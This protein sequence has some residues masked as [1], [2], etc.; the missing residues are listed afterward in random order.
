[1]K[2]AFLI[3][4]WTHFL[5]REIN[6]VNFADNSTC[7]RIFL[8]K[9]SII[10]HRYFRITH[11]LCMFTTI[12]YNTFIILISFDQSLKNMIACH[13]EKRKFFNPI[14]Q[15][16]VLRSMSLNFKIGDVTWKMFFSSATSCIWMKNDHLTAA[17]SSLIKMS[18]LKV[19]KKSL[20]LI[21]RRS[22]ICF[23]LKKNILITAWF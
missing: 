7:L 10:I 23:L 1:M 19:H 9:R 17:K 21:E 18:K 11:L 2:W 6:K 13:K 3:I 22:V 4:K 20:A 16:I 8:K 14:H 12:Q 5:G 15:V